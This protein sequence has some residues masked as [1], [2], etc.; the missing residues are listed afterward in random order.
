MLR[1]SKLTDYATQVAAWLAEHPE[2]FHSAREIADG[3][4]M[5][6]PTVS[7]VLKALERAGVT[8]AHRGKKGGYRL[9]GDPRT[10]SVAQVIRAMEGPIALTECS[11]VTSSCEQEA[12]CTVQSN[13]QR[14]NTAILNALDGVS[15]AE[16]SEPVAVQSLTNRTIRLLDQSRAPN[17]ERA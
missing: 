4:E 2:D 13:W 5:A 7:K 15:V 6:V 17:L 16:M 1:I 9:A 12:A 3:V 10:I 11:Q 8:E 14:I